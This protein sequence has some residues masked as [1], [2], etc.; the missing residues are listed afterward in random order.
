MP[1]V[2]IATRTQHTFVI[3][4]GNFVQSLTAAVSNIP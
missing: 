3:K 1:R 4:L 2:E